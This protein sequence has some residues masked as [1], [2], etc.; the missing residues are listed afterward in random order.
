[1]L[2]DLERTCAKHGLPFRRPSAVPRNS[3]P[4]ARVALVADRDGW[5]P[6]FTKAVLRANFAEDRDIG[7]PGVI[8]AI[9]EGLVQDPDAVLARAVAP[10]IKGRL[11]EHTEEAQRAGIFGAPSFIA[12]GE[13]FWGNDRLEDALE[14]AL[15]AGP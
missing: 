3:V 11:R 10:D 13:L 15:T 9:L 7:D 2:R 12:R 14:W 4:A 6:D 8:G 5:C 1:M